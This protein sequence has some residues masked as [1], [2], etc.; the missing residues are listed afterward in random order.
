[1]LVRFLNSNHPCFLGD[2]SNALWLDKNNMAAL[3]NERV[4]EI[5]NLGNVKLQRATEN[6]S[7]RLPMKNL[8]LKVSNLIFKRAFFFHCKAVHSLKQLLEN[9]EICVSSL[10]VRWWAVSSVNCS[11]MYSR[12][13]NSTSQKKKD[14]K[15]SAILPWEGLWW[16]LHLCIDEEDSKGKKITYAQPVKIWWHCCGFSFQKQLTFLTRCASYAHE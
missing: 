9:L 15:T 13:Q 2:K 12:P 7:L 11:L 10:R 4:A 16:S 5:W 8:M 3:N 14:I 1:M 6:C